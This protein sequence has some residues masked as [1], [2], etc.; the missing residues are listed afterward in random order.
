[1]IPILMSIVGA[2]AGKAVVSVFEAVT[3]SDADKKKDSPSEP[4]S[5]VKSN[6]GG[7]RLSED[8][9]KVTVSPTGTQKN[10]A[11]RYNPAK[12]TPQRLAKLA[13]E[14]KANGMVTGPEHALMLRVAVDARQTDLVSEQGNRFLTSKN[15]VTEMDQRAS[16]ALKSGNQAEAAQYQKLA[17][18]MKDIS[19]QAQTP[20]NKATPAIA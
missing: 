7:P 12:L 16:Q 19:A 8:A 20:Q 4:G 6:I 17:K 9:T 13:D 14:L 5:V 15:M 11:T 18:L 10:L 3:A 1:M 2:V